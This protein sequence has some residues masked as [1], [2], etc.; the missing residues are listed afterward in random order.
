MRRLLVLSELDLETPVKIGEHHHEGGI[1]DVLVPLFAT[2]HPQIGWHC[3]DLIDYA[4]QENAELKC[5]NPEAWEALPEV[6][7]WRANGS[8]VLCSTSFAH[9]EFVEDLWINHPRIAVLP[10]PVYEG[11]V[12]IAER[13]PNAPARRPQDPAGDQVLYPE[14]RIKQR[15]VDALK[16][17]RIRSTGKSLGFDENDTVLT[18]AAKAQVVHPLVRLGNLR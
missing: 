15:H 12:K 4:S 10:H 17:H 11:N 14:L 5:S 16:K 6:A 13:K 18:L 1:D 8:L 9:S 2:A 7:E 3:I